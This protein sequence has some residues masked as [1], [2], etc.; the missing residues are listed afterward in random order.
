[1]KLTVVLTVCL[2]AATCSAQSSMQEQV[3]KV[4]A[5]IIPMETNKYN[6]SFSIG[7]YSPKN[8]IKASAAGGVR[9]RSSGASSTAD[10]SYIWGSVTKVLTGTS[11]LRLV[12]QGKMS[13]DDSIVGH[14]DPFIKKMKAKNPGQNFSSLEDLFGPNV[15]NVTIRNLISMRSAI[16]DYDTATPYP[17]PPKDPFRAT[18]YENPSHTYAPADLL[19]VPWVHTGA[20][21]P[22]W[23]PGD[24]PR[25]HGN[26]YSSTN[27]VL[28]GM[29]LANAQGVDDWTDLDQ[30]KFIEPV[31]GDLG[32]LSLA[33]TGPPS[34]YSRVHGYDETNYNGNHGWPTP[35]NPHD[36]FPVAGVFG[37][38]TASDLVGPAVDI[39]TFIYDVYGPDH[40]LISQKTVDEMYSHSDET[41][42][43]Y[44][45]FNLT[46][47][48]GIH[49]PEGT[50]M[51]HLGATYGYQSIVGY[52]PAYDFSM[53]IATNIEIDDQAQPADAMCSVFNKV[54][55]II[56]KQPVPECTYK[57]GGY[58]SGGCQC[59]V[60][61]APTP[62][63]APGPGGKYTCFLK[64]CHP[65]THGI[66]PSESD[67]EKHCQ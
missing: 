46:R 61:G 40:K 53:A 32:K 51:G 1:M 26:C 67:C 63:P 34:Q 43:G 15:G 30:F 16:P 38:W 58:Y 55:A 45:T 29:V 18:V 64:K 49:P 50:I 47:R 41:G 65:F 66:Y 13:L 22:N 52:S 14:I 36:D 9:D 20:L 62:A 60:P 12:E 42:Y 5:E 23:T 57:S 21:V 19:S 25:S 10:D 8:Q 56:S 33:K 54:R 44:A 24:C 28:L 27:F 4:L 3:Q 7:V 37:G 17:S 48:S 6:C 2:L 39:A 59:H 11:I 31:M 35:E